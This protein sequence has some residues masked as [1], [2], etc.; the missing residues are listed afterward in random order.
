MTT[1]P[2]G[3]LRAAFEAV[4]EAVLGALQPGEDATL[5]WAAEQ[6][7]FCRFSGGAVRQA[8]A[9]D[10]AELTLRLIV[11]A[12]H[13]SATVDV[14]GPEAPT[15]A[16]RALRQLRALLPAL[17]I[18]PYLLWNEAGERLPAR[19]DPGV[20]ASTL[21]VGGSEDAMGR[22]VAA[23]RALGGA[24]PLDLVGILADG[25][26]AR[27]FAS[28]RGG[29][30]WQSV[31]RCHLDFSLYLHGD[32]AVKAAI[33]GPDAAQVDLEGAIGAA[34]SKLRLLALPA[35]ELPRGRY[36][37][38]LEPAAVAELL[39]LLS[40]GGFSGSELH[41]RTSPLLRLQAGEVA[42]SPAVHISEEL[43]G[44]A[45]PRISGD[46]FLRPEQVSLVKAGRYAGALVSPRSAIEHGLQHNGANDAEEPEA[47][48]LAAG[49]LDPAQALQ[50]VGDGVYVSN[51]WYL[52]WS[53]RAA[54]C[55]TGM[56]RFATFAV[57]DGAIAG[58]MQVM[59]FDDSLFRLLGEGLLA[60]GDRAETLPDAS[61]YGRRS[62]QSVRTPG[63]L[64]DGLA[65][66]L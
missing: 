59:R 4:S 55:A 27:G 18:D 48:T 52:N 10:Q 12:R 38:W 39:G 2:A 13:A 51:L 60:L 11:G 54:A 33:A 34:A 8:G 57:R 29:H 19:D 41:T 61:T 23:A 1:G 35:V 49:T 30:A 47:L 53:D 66:T 32:K 26:I 62:T 25:R 7:L 40:W 28:S 36:R 56:T 20:D 3:A 58:P 6:S 17:P 64:V 21:G 9:V 43:A 45:A 42:L 14:A 22:V 16:L 50:A 5:S 31:P 37:A 46:G 44:S 24:Q 63:A 65:F 15:A